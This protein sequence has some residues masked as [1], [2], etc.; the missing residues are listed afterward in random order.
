MLPVLP[1]AVFFLSPWT[2]IATALGA[3]SIPVIIHLLNRRR[4][5]IVPWAAMRFLVGAQKRSVRKI[6]IEQWLLLA[7]RTLMILLL[8]AAMVSVLPWLDPFWVR[9]FPSGISKTTARTGRTH[10]IIVIDGSFSMG[11]K[12]ADTTS[13]EKA[14]AFASQIVR[15]ARPGDGFSL[16][17][18]S[19][20]AQAVVAGPSDNAANVI[21]EIDELIMPHAN[22]DLAS[23]STIIER[24]TN[25]PSG[26]YHQRVLYFLSDMQKATFHGSGLPPN[27]QSSEPD[28]KSEFWERLSANT[29][30]AFVDVGETGIENAAVTNVSLNDN[31][32][33]TQTL[34]AVTAQIRNFG[35][36][37]RPQLRVDLL[38]GRGRPTNSVERDPL[39]AFALHL[40]EQ[41]TVNV[42]AGASVPVTFPLQFSQPGEFVIQVRI[43]EDTLHLDDSRS[44]VVNVQNSI[45]VTLVNGKST[46][47]REEHATHH[48]ATALRPVTGVGD[49]STSPFAV[50]VISEAQFSDFAQGDLESCS[51]LFLCDVPRFTD[52]RID[53]LESLL[54]RGGSVVFTLGP[55][56]DIESYNRM[57]YRDSAG[58]LPA[59]L[60]R[61]QQTAGTH[62]F[63]MVGDDA[64]FQFP[65]LQAFSDD[66]DRPALLSSR[67]RQYI[68]VQLP[69]KSTARR[70]LSF[71]SSDT[72]DRRVPDPA[73]LEWKRH[74]GKVLLIA[75]AVNL[76]W[77][78]WPGSPAYLPFMHELTRYAAS[79]GLPRVAAATEP[80]QFVPLSPHMAGNAQVHLP[81]SRLRTIIA[82]VSD[83]DPVLRMPETA[84][85]GI[86]RL[87]LNDEREHLFAVNVPSSY[88][89]GVVS[90]SD[91]RR[92]DPADLRSIPKT[93]F[94][95]V[96]DPKQVEVRVHT[97]SSDTETGPTARST[98]GPSVARTAVLVFLLLLAFESLLA[99]RF[100]SA[101]SVGLPDSGIAQSLPLWKRV[102]SIANALFIPALLT[103]GFCAVLF[104]ESVTGQFLGF[105]PQVLR[106]KIELALG[107]PP[108][109]AGEGTRWKL[110]YL[111]N[112][113]GNASA[114]RWL[115][116]ILLLVLGIAAVAIYRA[117]KAALGVK[118]P[119]EKSER[120]GV[121]GPMLVRI[122]LLV[123]TLLVLLP[124]L[125]L[126]FEREGW[127][128]VAVVFDTSRSFGATDDF[129]D[130]DVEATA[131][132]LANSWTKI[133][134][135]DVDVLESELTKIAGFRKQASHADRIVELDQELE[136]KK[137]LLIEMTTPKSRIN[138]AKALT[139][140]DESDWISSLLQRRQVKVHV[141]RCDAKLEKLEAVTD[142]KQITEVVRKVRLLRPTGESSQQ[143]NG[144]RGILSDFRGT[145]LGAIIFLTDGVVTDGEDLL[146]A[147]RAAARANVSLFLVGI[148]D[149]HEPRDVALHD[150]QADDMVNVRD[151]V[152]FEFRISKK[153]R[154]DVAT[155]PVILREMKPDGSLVEI[156]REM[157]SLDAD[158]PVKVRMF[159][160]AMEPGDKTY[161][162]DIP[163][164]EKETDRSNN[165]LEHRVHVADAK[166]IRVL[167]IE[168]FPHHDYRFIKTLLER[169]AGSKLGNRSIQLRV[170]LADSDRD[171]AS[172]DKSA[173]AE[174]PTQQELFAFD[175][176]I[177][178][179]VDPKHER[180][181]E[182]NLGLLRDFV[183]EKGGGMLFLSGSQGFMPH[184]YRST[185][186]ADIIPVVCSTEA[187]TPAEKTILDAGLRDGYRPLLTPVGQ[188][189]PV[190]RFVGEDAQNIEVWQQLSPLYFAA[191]RFSAKPTS[192]VLATHPQLAARNSK[193]T[194]VDQGGLH[195]LIVQQFVGNGRVLFFGFNETSRWR[196]REAEI[197]FNQFW[198][199]TVQ[200][201][202]RN[203]VGRVDLHLD[204][205][206]PYRRNE[207]IRV[208]VRFPDDAPAPSNDVPVKVFL[209]RSK[210]RDSGE[211]PSAPV[212]TQSLSLTKV[213]GSR[214]TYET[215]VTRT[216]EGEYRFVLAAPTP[217]AVRP[218]TSNR[219]LPPPGEMDRI[220]LDHA[221]LAQAAKESNGKFYNLA[222][223][224]SLLDDLPAG[225]RITLNEPRPPWLIWNQS[226]MFA[227]ALSLLT[228]EWI[229]RKRRRLL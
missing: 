204:K 91:L 54:K 126:H 90:E 123:L 48:L 206:T 209:E 63:S 138:L 79:N 66:R 106:S 116:P 44:L 71:L 213:K 208:T 52:A 179:D 152:N 162:V 224:D 67:F 194:N 78:S 85:S 2:A 207:P 57:L 95:V 144:I 81:D 219:V 61:V 210:L 13:F 167:Y 220:R 107:V 33:L 59:Q 223:V 222:D 139:T 137:S 37:D 172:Q 103:A 191:S 60:V 86:Y 99:W 190:L 82:P 120:R 181:G 202:A 159:T 136:S 133:S 26:N 105:L 170:L 88:S 92:I 192:E 218:E 51:C 17:L 217:A 117:E 109:S 175:T 211:P 25:Q 42:S 135:P 165:R 140:S 154:L 93:D 168:G 104:H 193:S 145:S 119:G 43:E 77:G 14:R 83:R 151:R 176:V 122:A 3:A 184:A 111:A 110:E 169:E 80:L 56:V 197:R 228:S 76:D 155:V 127:P 156:K 124:Q 182:R 161:V 9:L 108:A 201:L 195:P 20:P 212:E 50:R 34:N 131:A 214:A 23:A 16:I 227:L 199:Q 158:K 216:P 129:Q 147:A 84:I 97:E 200:Y 4:Y 198:L 22:A 39:P 70:L 32:V 142:A 72:S 8:I 178:G 229:M 149:A 180:L 157:V 121:F 96:L 114:D 45:P 18:M 6:R 113:T 125:R 55:N 118:V 62:H 153:G 27:P 102:M 115:V 141:Y 36:L 112:L 186:L 177:L 160:S 24:L 226:T 64:A 225:T 31:I 89:S 187:D 132:R 130:S 7:I 41:Q 134:K 19:S 183:R 40:I 58:I 148:G 49:K 65:P 146:Q 215:V 98:A 94:Q 47:P 12:V 203:K 87:M 35:A 75:T 69:Q 205:Q 74:N 21:Q 174:F 10:R 1:I 46:A 15:D 11:R 73:V 29:T 38:I 143:G 163:T 171:F 166:P 100:G 173:L 68:R 221:A 188:Q 189:H 30:V 196:F 53:R 150:L 28:P 128:D 185:P 164:H 101:R 5:R